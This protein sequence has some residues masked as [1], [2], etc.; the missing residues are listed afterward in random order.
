MA[1]ARAGPVNGSGHAPEML[2]SEKANG[3][4]APGWVSDTRTVRTPWRGTPAVLRTRAPS[5]SVVAVAR[6]RVRPPAP[7]WT[8]TSSRA[9]SGRWNPVA[10]TVPQATRVRSRWRWSGWAAAGP[11]PSSPSKR[12][13]LATRGDLSLRII[14]LPWVEASL[15]RQQVED[16]LV[17]VQPAAGGQVAGHDLQGQAGAVEPGHVDG[18]ELAPAGLLDRPAEGVGAGDGPA[19]VVLAQPDGDGG[20]RR[21]RP[22]EG[23]GVV[24]AVELG[25]GDVG[26]GDPD[27]AAGR[28]VGQDA[29]RPAALGGLGR[30]GQAGLAERLP[31][32]AAVLEAWVGEQVAGPGRCRRRGRRGRHRRRGRRTGPGAGGRGR[33]RQG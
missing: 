2:S 31:A 26:D 7:S 8:R 33:R 28:G 17:H 12:A 4:A 23:V 19:V 11:A 9:D 22:H 14:F 20:A 6:F 21:R 3:L 13:A 16:D 24:A 15:A 29:Q 25:Q 10:C 30:P 32:P 18:P 27:R 5:L 1:G